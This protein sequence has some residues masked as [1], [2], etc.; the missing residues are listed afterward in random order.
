MKSLDSI[1]AEALQ[2]SPKERLHLAHQI[3]TS[4]DGE[5]DSG[6]EAAWEEEIQE[7]LRKFD[8]GEIKGIPGPEVMQALKRK[9]SR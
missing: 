5:P 6:A 3:L 2:L 8:S 1:A 4:V 9:L 7:R